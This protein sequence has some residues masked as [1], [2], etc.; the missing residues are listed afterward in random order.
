VKRRRVGHLP[1]DDLEIVAP[2]VAEFDP[3]VMLVHPEIRRRPAVARHELQSE[4]ARRKPA[5]A[6]E[7]ADADDEIAE[8]IHAAHD[9]SLH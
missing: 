5:P 6:F 3:V 4:H 8:L 1:A 9:P 7:V 2:P